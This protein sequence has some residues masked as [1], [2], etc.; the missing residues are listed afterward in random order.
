MNTRWPV[1]SHQHITTSPCF[2]HHSFRSVFCTMLFCIIIPTVLQQSNASFDTLVH[3]RVLMAGVP[4]KP[5][6]SNDTHNMLL[7]KNCSSSCQSQHSKSSPPFLPQFSPWYVDWYPQSIH[8]RLPQDFLLSALL[9]SDIEDTEDDLLPRPPEHTMST[10]SA[11]FLI[12][13]IFK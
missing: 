10:L 2:I 11:L 3:I 13:T 8:V 4:G 1:S 7:T 12:F 9:A 5:D 6:I